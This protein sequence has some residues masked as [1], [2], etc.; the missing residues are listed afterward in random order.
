VVLNV[1]IAIRF[2]FL[3]CKKKMVDHRLP[4]SVKGS[5]VISGDPSLLVLVYF[6][7]STS[8][9]TTPP[10]MASSKPRHKAPPTTV[11]SV[12][13]PRLNRAVFSSDTMSDMGTVAK[14]LGVKEE[15]S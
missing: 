13:L 11:R 5:S 10:S 9:L 6:H 7:H 4:A 14:Q 12:S 2:S 15:K 3:W 1:T 8:S